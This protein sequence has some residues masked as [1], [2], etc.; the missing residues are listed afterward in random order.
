[1]VDLGEIV[2]GEAARYLQTHFVAPVQ[3]KALHDIAHCRTE[4]MGTVASVCDD[5]STEYSLFRSCRNR[6]CPM[7]QGEARAKWL[8]ARE[9]ELLPVPYLHI[10][11]GVPRELIVLA[12]YCPKEFYSALI[13]AAGQAIIDVGWADLHIQLGSLVQL[14][15]WGE[16]LPLHPHTH[17]VV[18]MGGFSEDRARWVSFEQ[19]DLRREALED[20]FRTLVCRGIQT[21]ARRGKL[22][23]LPPTIRVETLLAA[24]MNQEWSVH[25]Q[26]ALGGPEKLLGY[27]ARYTYRVAITNDRIESYEDHRITFRCRNENDSKACTLDGQEFLR[28][29]LMHV[30]PKG[31]VRIRSF[32]FLGNRNRKQNIERARQLIGQAR[33]ARSSKGVRSLRLCPAC[34][35]KRRTGA[36]HFAPA[37]DVAPQLELSLRPPPEPVAA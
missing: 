9:E 37:P 27:L 23:G 20:R 15:T 24:A 34:A 13:H 33:P 6:S 17:C 36:S 16:T 12:L 19:H 5:C 1:M 29:F 8:E 21:M 3:R 10:V 14:H 26:P 18:P 2:R 25:A 35:R 30:P 4:A 32:G 11:F 7:C 31:F 28:R 22:G